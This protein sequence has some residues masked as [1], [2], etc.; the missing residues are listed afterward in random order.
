MNSIGNT[1]SSQPT[2]CHVVLD[3]A[4]PVDSSEVS[5]P[6]DV[7]GAFCGTYGDDGSCTLSS[8]RE[9]IHLVGQTLCG[10]SG[11]PLGLRGIDGNSAHEP[12]VWMGKNAHKISHFDSHLEQTAVTA[13]HPMI[14]K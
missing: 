5:P 8:L 10:R 14:Y 11:F 2:F 7:N 9:K 4:L 6:T 13:L 1:R 12:G 3:T